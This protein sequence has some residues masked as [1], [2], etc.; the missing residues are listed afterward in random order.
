M[1]KA[2]SVPDPFSPMRFLDP[3]GR[4]CCANPKCTARLNRADALGRFC[5]LGVAL[6]PGTHKLETKCAVYVQ[7]CRACRELRA[8]RQAYRFL[9][10]DGP[11][12]EAVVAYL[13]GNSWRH[14]PS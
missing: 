1:A 2:V 11:L 4:A 10:G 6:V 5:L 13:A 7:L 8:W 9:V 3:D 14:T 12:R